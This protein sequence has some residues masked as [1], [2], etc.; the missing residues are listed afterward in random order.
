MHYTNACSHL[1]G[2]P[3]SLAP[4]LLTSLLAGMPQSPLS[5]V[6]RRAKHTVEVL[7]LHAT[8]IVHIHEVQGKLQKGTA[9]H[10]EGAARKKACGQKSIG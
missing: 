9:D 4:L 5:A 1:N 8:V 2:L 3:A 7:E 10:S 6:R